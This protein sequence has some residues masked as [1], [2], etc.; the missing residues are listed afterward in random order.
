MPAAA[1]MPTRPCTSSASR[2]SRTVFLSAPFD[3]PSGSKGPGKSVTPTRPYA[4]PSS[5]SAAVIAD[6]GL[7]DGLIGYGETREL[8][9]AIIGPLLRPNETITMWMRSIAV[10]GRGVRRTAFSSFCLIC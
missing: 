3:R 4:K 2:H 7:I 8:V 6:V 1:S 10:R 5:L 9:G